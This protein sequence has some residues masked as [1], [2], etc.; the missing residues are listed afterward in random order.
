[1][2]P[3]G[4]M[5]AGLELSPR[6]HPRSSPLVQEI[7]RELMH[8]RSAD[9]PDGSPVTAYLVFLVRPD[10]VHS[11]YQARS[12]LEPLGIAFGYELI[13]QNLVVDIPN[14]D[15]LT[16]WDGSVPLDVP[17][18]SAPRSQPALALRSAAGQT[19]DADGLPSKSSARSCAD[20]QGGA[21]D[22]SDGAA[23]WPAASTSRPGQRGAGSSGGDQTEPED[24]VWPSRSRRG[25]EA[26]RPAASVSLPA[27][28]GGA[29]GSS[30]M[31]LA[32][33]RR[34]GRVGWPGCLR[35]RRRS[36]A[37]VCW[38][39]WSRGQRT[40]H[41]ERPHARWRNQAGSGSFRRFRYFARS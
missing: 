22:L 34:I 12:C 33:Q 28:G 19:T 10:G 16:T 31:G 40:R 13:E 7:V 29:T 17:P 18:Q 41:G 37:S 27:E 25:G 21:G 36:G 3:N 6:I 11:Y 35:C 5:F 23:G 39:P 38:T 26:D 30:G 14:F 20:A 32:A 24:F 2:Q 9:T 1:M 15:D 4:P 8:I